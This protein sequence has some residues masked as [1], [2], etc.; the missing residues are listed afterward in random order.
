MSA[1]TAAPPAPSSTAVRHLPSRIGLLALAA[2]SAW[3]GS[4]ATFAPQSFYDS[5]PGFGRHWISL[6]GAYNQHLISDV[7]GLNLALA[8]ITLVAAVSFT[9][10]FVRA[11]CVGWLVY[12]VPHLLYHATHLYGLDGVDQVGNIVSLS[13]NV[14]VPILVL[15]A[16][17]WTWPARRPPA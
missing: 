4:W 12:S 13:F 8:V 1:V 5:F 16:S 9:P 2:G 7:G 3:V 6:D 15:I 17:L 11:V 14:V 10:A